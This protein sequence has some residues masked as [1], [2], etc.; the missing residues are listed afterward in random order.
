MRYI[1]FCLIVFTALAGTAYAAMTYES[2][3]ESPGTP[4]VAVY[5]GEV[6]I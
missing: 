4:A 3:E 1:S 2:N 5:L 6:Y